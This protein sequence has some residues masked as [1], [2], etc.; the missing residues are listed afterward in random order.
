MPFVPAVVVMTVVAQQGARGYVVSAAILGLAVIVA[1]AMMRVRRV[2]L[3]S[4]DPT[5][6]SAGRGRRS[7]SNGRR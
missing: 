6:L 4:A 7:V 2:D 3:S 5:Q 1:V